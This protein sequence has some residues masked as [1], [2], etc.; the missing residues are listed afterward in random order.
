MI[1]TLSDETAIA[2]LDK[3]STDDTFRETFSANPRSA[4]AALGHGPALD[5]SQA[6]GIWD[7]WL[8]GQLAS[9]EVIR[10]SRDQ[11]LRQVTTAKAGAHPIT[12]EMQP[13]PSRLAA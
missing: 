10:A 4:L 13:S 8:I 12:L 7:C 3:L 1:H 2:L 11:L 9:K 5:A 6:E